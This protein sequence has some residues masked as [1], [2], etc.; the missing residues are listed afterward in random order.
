M[1]TKRCSK[2]GEVKEVEE[3]RKTH[4]QCKNCIGLLRKKYDFLNREKINER[5]RK[6]VKNN[7]AR[8][9]RDKG[10]YIAK[11]SSRYIDALIKHQLRIEDITPEMIDIKRQQIIIYR[12]LKEAKNGIT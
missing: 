6:Y 10:K 1:D 8:N 4:N 7:R 9:N 3:F 12:L 5:Q 2:C 11:M